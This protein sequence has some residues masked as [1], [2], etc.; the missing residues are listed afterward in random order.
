MVH[1][2]TSKGSYVRNG[3]IHIIDDNTTILKFSKLILFNTVT[4]NLI[5]LIRS[6]NGKKIMS[7]L[8]KYMEMIS[9]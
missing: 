7:D 4:Q 5:R 2:T 6:H 1:Q 3:M 9:F 8:Y